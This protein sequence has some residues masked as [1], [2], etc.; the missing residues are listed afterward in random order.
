ME[1]N[2]RK[3]DWKVIAII[4]LAV[5]LMVCFMRGCG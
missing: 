3:F 5:V 4:I 2:K 1:E